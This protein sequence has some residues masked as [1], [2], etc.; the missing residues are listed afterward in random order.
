MNAWNCISREFRVRTYADTDCLSFLE[1]PGGK[2][3]S[4]LEQAPH[5]EYSAAQR[6]G[7]PLPV[8]EAGRKEGQLQPNN[9]LWTFI[10]CAV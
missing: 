1:L 2:S 4:A 3:V 8:T 5:C 10:Y 9:S 7:S 6:G